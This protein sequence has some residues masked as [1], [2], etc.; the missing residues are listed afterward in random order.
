MKKLLLTASVLAVSAGNAFAQVA[1]EAPVTNFVPPN[2]QLS[3]IVQTGDDNVATV[4]QTGGSEGVSDIN[5]VGDDN[6]ATVTQSETS[7]ASNSFNTPANIADI[8]QTGEASNATVTQNNGDARGPSNTAVI[9]QDAFPLAT[10]PSGF[11]LDATII[12]DGT[13]NQS[14]I[15]QTGAVF[16]DS[17]GLNAVNNQ[18]GNGNLSAISQDGDTDAA[19]FTDASV[20]QSG[21]NNQ[22][23]V[24]QFGEN[25]LGT[26]NQLGADN[27]S[28][29]DQQGDS[30][31]ADIFQ[32]LSLIHI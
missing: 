20:T 26:V 29:L 6:V 32:N 3:D 23:D 27:S 18:T 5:Q 17:S 13:G 1:P 24:S 28:F 8:D 10:V 14:S 22:S 19:P 11:N 7:G 25:L 2:V 12:Q 21:D 15:V 30:H 16:G 31:V 9:R 4:D